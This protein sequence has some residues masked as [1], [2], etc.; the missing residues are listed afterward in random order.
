MRPLDAQAAYTT[1]RRR[2]T[3]VTLV[4]LD[5]LFAQFA[6][7]C[8]INI[9][10][11]TRQGRTAHTLRQDFVVLNITWAPPP[12]I[13]SVSHVSVSPL[14]SV[15]DDWTLMHAATADRPEGGKELSATFIKSPAPAARCTL[16][17]PDIPHVTSVTFST[18]RGTS[19]IRP[20]ALSGRLIID[21]H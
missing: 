9:L 6:A 16:S 11:T 8:L 13:E 7:L 15:A 19:Q 1:A 14:V 21:T 17:V 4:Y 5:L 12:A 18:K 20:S 3:L 10:L 2:T